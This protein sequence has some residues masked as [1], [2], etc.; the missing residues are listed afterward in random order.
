MRGTTMQTHTGLTGGHG[1]PVRPANASNS[2]CLTCRSIKRVLADLITMKL[3]SDEFKAKLSVLKENI[4][5]HAHEE[6]EAKLFPLLRR[7]MGVDELAALGND[8]LA[9]FEELLPEHP[10]K[11]VPSETSKAAPLPP[12]S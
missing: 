1:N 3:D 4:S 7:A 9:M 8:V 5:H 2:R 12:A 11:N 10:Y 6:E